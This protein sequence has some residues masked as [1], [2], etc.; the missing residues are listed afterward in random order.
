M[1]IIT[2]RRP[3][4]SVR[5]SPSRSASRTT[6]GSEPPTSRKPANPRNTST[7]ISP[8]EAQPCFEKIHGSGDVRYFVNVLNIFQLSYCVHWVE[9][10]FC[11]W[12]FFLSKALM[13][14]CIHK[15]EY[16]FVCG[17]FSNY[18]FLSL[19]V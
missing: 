10:I 18:N 11:V 8:V 14:W 4:S 1:G 12:F 6:T 3:T 16:I 17:S 15:V 5:S 2:Q 13:I 19:V 7:D 9:R